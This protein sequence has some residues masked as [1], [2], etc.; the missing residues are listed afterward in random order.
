MQEIRATAAQLKGDGAGLQPA[1]ANDANAA[2]L[3]RLSDVERGEVLDCLRGDPKSEVA[4]LEKS[5][6]LPRTLAM[7]MRHG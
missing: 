4:Q 5:H 6:E 2:D 7:A 3:R 1:Y